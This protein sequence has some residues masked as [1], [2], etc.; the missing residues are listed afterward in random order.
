MPGIISYVPFS[1]WI[2]IL[3][4]SWKELLRIG[5]PILLGLLGFIVAYQHTF[6]R[7][8]YSPLFFFLIYGLVD[9]LLTI[10]IYGVLFYSAI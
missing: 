3:P 9:G 8:N 10:A 6:A 7:K 2:P 1:V 4:E 5:L